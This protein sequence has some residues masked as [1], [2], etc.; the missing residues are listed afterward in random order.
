[1][2]FRR[3]DRPAW[4]VDV[5]MPSGRVR[6]STGTNDRATA[7]AIERAIFDLASRREWDLLAA[8]R[9]GRLTVGDVFDAHRTRDLAA[10]RLRLSDTDLRP[11]IEPWLLV[12]GAKAK[13]DTVSHYRTVLHR[14]MPEGQPFP[15]SRFTV[16]D[17]EPWLATTYC[18]RPGTHRKAHA[19]LS[20]FAAFL[21]RQGVIEINPLR[22][23]PAPAP[24]QPRLRYLEVEQMIALA[25]AQAE[26][27]Q[28]L[29][30]RIHG[31]GVEIS[32]ALAL[33]AADVDLF[34]KEVRAQGTKTHAR[35]R[36]VRVAEW[37]WPY[38]IARVAQLDLN[39]PLFPT[40]RWRALDSQN[41]ACAKLGIEKGYRLHD[42]RHSYA[43]RAARA[44]TPAELIAAQ[45]GHANAMMVIKIYGRFMPSQADRDLWEMRAA[46][47]DTARWRELSERGLTPISVP[48]KKPS[49]VSNKTKS[50]NP[51]E[52]DD[53]E[54]SRGG[55]RTRDPGIMSAV[56]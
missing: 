47:M 56:L 7:R 2:V 31:T 46:A 32:V 1:M 33:R 29:C 21:V 54:S 34:R 19:A 23:F 28:S 24:S 6:L 51:L 45:L 36:I 53:F 14:L 15:A 35:D 10:L 52:L 20:Q 12:H 5:P 26:P 18:G 50:P 25:D 43:V 16:R 39:A 3:P 8:V 40:D 38:L 48:S 11:L 4:Y 41:E 27:Y 55:T 37:A 44:G 30:A 22:Q 9:D 42:A 13:P 17:L 49:A